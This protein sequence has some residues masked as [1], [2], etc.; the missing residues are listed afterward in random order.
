MVGS[1]MNVNGEE[2]Y[3]SAAESGTDAKGNWYVYVFYGGTG[4]F[5]KATGKAQVYTALDFNS[6][7]KGQFKSKGTGFLKY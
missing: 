3:F 7:T 4:Q 5:K 2:I 1:Y 6:G